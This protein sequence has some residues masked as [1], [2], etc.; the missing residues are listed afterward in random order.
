MKIGFIAEPYEESGA[1]GMGYAVLETMRNLPLVAS[2]H[3]YIYYS[4]KPIRRDL[5]TAHFSNILIPKGFVRQFMWFLR[6][7]RDVDVLLFTT[8]LLPLLVPRVPVIMFC[9]EL[10]SQKIRP[11]TAAGQL[12]DFMRDHVLMPLSLSQ[13]VH[14]IAPSRATKDDIMKFYG[15]PSG[16]ISVV[17]EGFQ[18]MTQ[19]KDQAEQIESKMKPFFFFAGRVKYRKNVHTIVESFILFKKRN[20]SSMKLVIAG[21]YG[22][23]YYE[24]MRSRLTAEGLEREVFFLG[25][26]PVGMLYSLYKDATAFVFPSLNEGFGM[27]IVE[28]MSLGTPVITSS[29]SSM[30]EVA[31]EAALLVDPLSSGSIVAA[32]ETISS[33]DSCRKILIM[34]GFEQA[35][36]FSWSKMALESVRIIE[37]KIT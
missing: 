36:K 15:T 14:I 16:K 1:S 35:S 6:L 37:Q 32:M 24:D 5:V 34:K 2:Q 25:Y 31:G 7:P 18:D 21:G 26:V 9:K 27:P 8:P 13:A 33:D 10:G 3:E 4:S 17:Y 20:R 22:G 19:F 30:T 11:G 23:A 29:I 28:A 12:R